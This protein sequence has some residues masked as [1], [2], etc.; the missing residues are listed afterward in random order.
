MYVFM[1]IG[2]IN[3]SLKKRLIIYASYIHT[4]DN[5]SNTLIKKLLKDTVSATCVIYPRC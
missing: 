1:L 3:L 4:S 2:A 5:L